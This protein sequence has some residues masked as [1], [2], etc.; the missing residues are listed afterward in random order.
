MII[1]IHGLPRRWFDYWQ[2]PVTERLARSGQTI[3][4][5]AVI[6]LQNSS[7]PFLDG[8][9]NWLQPENNP[10]ITDAH[11]PEVIQI[12]IVLQH[13]EIPCLRPAVSSL[14]AC[15]TPAL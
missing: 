11:I 15:P 9:K 14:G 2:K 5:S 7:F 1:V 13:T 10:L 6:R 12:P 8:D 3:R 4:F